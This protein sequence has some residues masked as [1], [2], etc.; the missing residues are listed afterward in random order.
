[1]ASINNII[2]N[3]S[4]VITKVGKIEAIVIGVCVRGERNE[5]I[6]YHLSRYAHG[7]YKNEWLQSYEVEIKIDNSQKAGFHNSKTLIS[8]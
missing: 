5:H 4:K 7:E 2:P 8:N 1:M 3:G 6:E